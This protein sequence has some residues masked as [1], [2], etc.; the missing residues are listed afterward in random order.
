MARRPG[1]SLDHAAVVAGAAD[2]ADSQGLEGLT[3]AALAVRLGVQ[4]PSLH[5]HVAGLPGLRRDLALVGLRELTH[6]LERVAMGKSGEPA[7]L[8][9]AHA[10]RAFAHEHPGLYAAALRAPIPT[11]VEWYAAY[12]DQIGVFLAVL[13]GDGLTGEDAL[14]ATRGLHS[15]LHGFVALETGG[16][17]VM[18]LDRDESF[19]RL[20]HMFATGLHAFRVQDLVETGR[21]DTTLTMPSQPRATHAR[22]PQGNHS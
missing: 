14:H 6:R 16:G 3:L 13:A 8:A 10:Y 9:L 22:R 2:L 5:H 4:Q 19:H 17:F 18:P 20:M 11:D 21:R 15:L 12:E 7:L 1:V